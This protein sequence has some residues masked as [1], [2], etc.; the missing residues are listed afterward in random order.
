M[1]ATTV[2]QQLCKSCMTYFMFYC[3]FY[4]TCDRSLS[5]GDGWVGEQGARVP[6]CTGDT[7]PHARAPSLS[8]RIPGKYFSGKWYEKFDHF[9]ANVM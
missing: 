4:F 7:C 1:R 8:P 6:P 2:V 5:A 9:R 3:M